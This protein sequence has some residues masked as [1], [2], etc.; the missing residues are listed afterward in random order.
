MIFMSTMTLNPG[1]LLDIIIVP[2][3][4]PPLPTA[5]KPLNTE[6]FQRDE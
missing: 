2:I 6:F 3:R 1:S 4:A 5:F